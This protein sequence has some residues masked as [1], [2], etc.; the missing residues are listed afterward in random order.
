MLVPQALKPSLPPGSRQSR[1]DKGDHVMQTWVPGQGLW[2][3][4]IKTAAEQLMTHA[5]AHW[6]P[7]V[8]CHW[9]PFC[10]KLPLTH[11]TCNCFCVR[12]PFAGFGLHEMAPH[13]TNDA[14]LTHVG[15]QCASAAWR[16]PLINMYM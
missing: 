12:F 5:R 6:A 15:R 4:G 8:R 9:R 16:Y 13:T 1:L 11:L 10:C 7:L 3:D 14:T 2:T